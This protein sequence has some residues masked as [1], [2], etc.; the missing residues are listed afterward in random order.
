MGAA[1][2]GSTVTEYTGIILDVTY[3][4]PRRFLAAEEP[5]AGGKF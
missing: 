2:N 5:A 4:I 3:S 1:T